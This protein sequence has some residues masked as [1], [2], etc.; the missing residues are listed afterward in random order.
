MPNETQ[1]KM[2]MT[3]THAGAHT[4]DR[5]IF[6]MLKIVKTDSKEKMEKSKCQ[7]CTLH[8]GAF[9]IFCPKTQ[10]AIHIQMTVYFLNKVYW[11]LNH[12]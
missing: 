8:T 11:H 12:R 1:K 2:P 10:V 9:V 5:I 6:N 4:H 3:K 7:N